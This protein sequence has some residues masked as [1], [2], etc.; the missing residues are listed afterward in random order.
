MTML[1]HHEERVSQ[2]LNVYVYYMYLR[3]DSVMVSLFASG[4]FRAVVRNKH[5]IAGG[6]LAVPNRRRFRICGG[7]A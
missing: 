7:V 6:S 2:S 4:L 1:H 3:H 5:G